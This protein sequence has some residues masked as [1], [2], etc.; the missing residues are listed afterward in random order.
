MENKLY[1]KVKIYNSSLRNQSLRII[2][3]G[4]LLFFLLSCSKEHSEKYIGSAE[5]NDETLL[6][7]DATF[8]K[9][10]FD[11]YTI[12]LHKESEIGPEHELIFNHIKK[13]VGKYPIK[14]RLTGDTENLPRASFSTLKYQRDVLLELHLGFSNDSIE[15][16]VTIDKVGFRKIEGRFQV[17]LKSTSENFETIS[18]FPYLTDTLILTEGKFLA[19]RVN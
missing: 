1:F 17:A 12:F 6:T 4:I 10:I 3:H 8:R 2:A 5:L 16:W 11:K 14:E 18:F 9:N 15:S 13:E 19:R 7:F